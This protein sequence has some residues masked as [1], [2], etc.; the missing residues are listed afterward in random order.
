MIKKFIFFAIYILLSSNVISAEEELSTELMQAIEDANKN[1]SS[2]IALNDVKA[3]A[4]DTKELIEM[5]SKVETYFTK[6]GSAENAV[7][8]SKKSKGLLVEIEKSVSIKDFSAATN[9]AT[10]LS[11]TC[12]SC[13][14]FYK[15]E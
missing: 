8:L 4:I 9:L 7:E 13:H 6:K 3:A 14:T 10:D 11:R 12:R 1:L 2:N 15:K 5:F